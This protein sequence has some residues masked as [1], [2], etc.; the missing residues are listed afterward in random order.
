MQLPRDEDPEIV[1]NDPKFAAF[2]GVRAAVDGSLID[3]WASLDDASRFRSQK[4]H[5]SQNILAGT[6]S[7]MQTCYMMSGWEGS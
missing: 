1:L 7:D 2:E 6:T 3:L 4:G 5:V